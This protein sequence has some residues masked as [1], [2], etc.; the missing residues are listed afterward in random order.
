MGLVQLWILPVSS[1]I[2]FASLT[3]QGI[4]WLRLG[5]GDAL[6]ARDKYGTGKA[7]DDIAQ[8]WIAPQLVQS[9]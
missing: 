9:I 7:E 3:D 2:L 5:P 1:F 8:V 4:G 6:F